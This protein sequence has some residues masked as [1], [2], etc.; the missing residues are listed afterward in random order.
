MEHRASLVLGLVFNA[1]RP[2]PKTDPWR[3]GHSYACRALSLPM[4]DR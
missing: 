4:A 1:L 2:R 3:L